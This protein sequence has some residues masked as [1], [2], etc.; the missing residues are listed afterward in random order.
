MNRVE[1]LYEFSFMKLFGIGLV[2]STH[3]FDRLSF[4]P[5]V[6]RGAV[7]R[8]VPHVKRVVFHGMEEAEGV[9]DF[10]TLE[11]EQRRVFLELVGGCVN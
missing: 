1:D 7:H 11:G 9:L 4:K 3:R 8:T 5:G 2:R 10:L 6:F